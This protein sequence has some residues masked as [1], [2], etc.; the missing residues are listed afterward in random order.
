M[1]VFCFNWG[2]DR[3]LHLPSRPLHFPRVFGRRKRRGA[4][5]EEPQA[6][7]RRADFERAARASRAGDPC[8][9][10]P[11]ARCGAGG[12]R[13]GAFTG[14]SAFPSRKRPP[15]P[16]APTRRAG[17]AASRSPAVRSRSAVVVVFLMTRNDGSRHK[18]VLLA[19]KSN[20][21]CFNCSYKK[22]KQFFLKKPNSKASR[23]F[24]FHQQMALVVSAIVWVVFP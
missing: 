14:E 18:A 24:Q 8:A 11:S 1:S 19:P 4:D 23:I 20:R 6:S 17:E 22:D 2:F 10:G 13:G 16:D 5:P 3:F 15:G 7:A 9:R 21:C 12:G